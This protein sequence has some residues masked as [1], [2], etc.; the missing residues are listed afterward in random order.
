MMDSSYI[1]GIDAETGATRAVAK[2]TDVLGVES[3]PVAPGSSAALTESRP[4]SLT[5]FLGG[6]RQVS[7]VDVGTL[8][9]AVAGA[10]LWRKHRVL[11]FFTGA[12]AGY[13]IPL[14]AKVDRRR[15]ALCNLGITSAGVLGSFTVKEHPVVG[16]V[17]G[18]MGGGV[19]SY[20]AGCNPIGGA[21]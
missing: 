14:L 11:G 13:N 1:N 2:L 12:S 17:L 18:W 8:V 20:A 4:N 10:L 21:R 19:L 16:F 9:G 6:V 5:R 7:P 3:T 15:A